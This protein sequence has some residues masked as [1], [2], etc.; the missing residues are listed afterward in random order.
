MNLICLWTFGVAVL[1]A[2]HED[3]ADSANVSRPIER[4]KKNGWHGGGTP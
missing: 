4:R 3:T 2:E 1:K